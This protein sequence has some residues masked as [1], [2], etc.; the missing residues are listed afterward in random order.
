MKK[1]GSGILLAT[2][3]SI[4][5]ICQRAEAVPPL[6]AGDVPTV[7][8][9]H[10]EWFVGTRYQ[11]TGAIERQVPFTEVVYGISDRQEVTFEV[12]YLVSQGRQGFG[13]AVV[14]TKY[15]F[16]KEMDRRPG[17]AGSFEAKLD[18]GSQAKGFGTGA[19]E[20]DLRLRSQKTFGRFTGIVNLGYTFVGEPEENGVRQKRRDVLFTAF[21]QEYQVAPKTKL[22]S[23]IYWKNS[24]TPHSPDRLAADVGFKHQLLPH[25]SIHAAVGKSLRDDNVGGPKLRVYAGIKAE[26]PLGKE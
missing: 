24:D 14:G 26:F 22:L 20:Y 23:E 8:K 1:A 7:D 4:L 25:L 10:V 19:M 18:T 13:D 3:V 6:V 11:K 15:Q 5:A 9:H 12:P 17:V 2:A 16:L 21:A